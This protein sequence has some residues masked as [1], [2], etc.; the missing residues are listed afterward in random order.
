MD[1]LPPE[2]IYDLTRPTEV[3]V[4]PDGDRVAFAASEADRSI[5]TRLFSHDSR[6]RPQRRV[7]TLSRSASLERDSRPVRTYR[8]RH[9]RACPSLGCETGKCKLGICVGQTVATAEPTDFARPLHRWATLSGSHSSGRRD[10]FVA[11]GPGPV[12]GAEFVA[13]SESR[14]L[15]TASPPRT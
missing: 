6:C 2:A 14:S 13:G 3:A 15:D 4:S 12:G 1:E 10:E 9:T 11:R 7:S 5:R 8:G